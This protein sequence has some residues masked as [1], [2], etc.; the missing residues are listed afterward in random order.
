MP[1][2]KEIAAHLAMDESTA[3]RLM[4]RLQLDWVTMPMDTIR[5]AYI[6]HLRGQAAGHKS[7]DGMDLTRERALTEQVD[8]ELKQLAL[9]EKKGQ[10]VNLAQLE[11]ALSRMVA[12]FRTEMLSRDDKLKGEI[13][14]LY[15][16]NLDLAMLTEHT[17]AALTQLARFEDE[18]PTAC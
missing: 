6:E 18:T 9:A 3:S 4:Q 17:R 5:V 14:A 16:I 2:Q 10:L 7:Q 1:T 13:D 15:G 12:A 11:P 8:R